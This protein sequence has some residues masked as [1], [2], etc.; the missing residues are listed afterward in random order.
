MKNRLEPVLGLAKKG[1]LVAQ[2]WWGWVVAR[3]RLIIVVLCGI[4][5]AVGAWVAQTYSVTKTVEIAAVAEP[6]SATVR[7]ND[8][9]RPMSPG[10]GCFDPSSGKLDWFGMNLPSTGFS[11]DTVADTSSGVDGKQWALTAMSPSVQPLDWYADPGHSLYMEV[12]AEGPDRHEVLYFGRTSHAL[13]VSE[14]KVR[15]QYGQPYPYAA[16]LPA[17]GGSVSFDSEPPVR[18][19][20]GTRMGVSAE[21]PARDSLSQSV[22]QIQA[23]P[24]YRQR[25]DLTL[26]GP[27]VDVLG[28][29]VSISLPAGRRAEIYAGLQPVEGL[30]RGERTTVV[31]RTPFAVRL[32][33]HP[34]TSAWHQALPDAWKNLQKKEGSGFLDKE[35]T[36]ALGPALQD[37]YPDTDRLPHYSVHLSDVTVPTPGA[38]REFARKS[39]DSGTV[40][41]ALSDI[42]SDKPT[43]SFQLP[44][45][46]ETLE[47]GVFG[48]LASLDSNSLQGQIFTDGK[49]VS[50]GR[51]QE[52]DLH[53][54]EGLTTG[55]YQMTPLVSAGLP[56]ATA[57]VAGDAKVSIDGTPV[58]RLPFLP[59][60]GIALVVILLGLL[61]EWIVHW[62]LSDSRKD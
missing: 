36:I 47:V 56:T 46:T 50:F 14:E 35:S 3:P 27:A 37:R 13:I 48:P 7:L 26:R 9:V 45:V 33:P 30:H 62:G 19:G 52:V 4:V 1:L 42:E 8:D 40:A 20:F 2:K 23:E 16:L 44:P 28:P 60:L 34:A 11:L 53:S 10:C 39:T 5:F 21:A 55:R 6:G 24:D 58:N 51:G 43:Y 57:N 49:A 54:D 59:Y 25:T 32:I 15:V 22:G 18:A 17:A 12:I 41:P 61:V 31:L 29:R 38:W